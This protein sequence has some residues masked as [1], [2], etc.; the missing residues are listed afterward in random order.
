M[1]LMY[2]AMG[3]SVMNEPNGIITI[4]VPDY[5][6]AAMGGLIALFTLYIRL[7]MHK[8]MLLLSEDAGNGLQD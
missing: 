4:V 2:F 8:K 6:Y 1:S 7:I 3:L 5:Y